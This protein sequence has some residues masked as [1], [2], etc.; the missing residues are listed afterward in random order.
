MPASN[1]NSSELLSIDS[2]FFDASDSRSL[3]NLTEMQ[4][5]NEYIMPWYQQ[6]MWSTLFGL[7][8]TVAAGGN[9]TVIWIVLAH[10]RMRT[11]TNY[12]ILN[13]S[14]ADTMVSTLNVG[15]LH[16]PQQATL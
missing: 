12:F 16:V 9:I 3:M 13:L 10:K 5:R 6:V 11:V 7:M 4:E 1:S 15:M 8:V 2:P 14:L